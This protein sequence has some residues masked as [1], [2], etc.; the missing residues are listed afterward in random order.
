MIL[1]RRED[2]ATSKCFVLVIELLDALPHQEKMTSWFTGCS[3]IVFFLLSG[4]GADAWST[5]ESSVGFRK[6]LC[7]LDQPRGSRRVVSSSCAL[8]IQTRALL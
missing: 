3:E 6:S 4:R 2:V 5:C 1:V 8:S 7:A